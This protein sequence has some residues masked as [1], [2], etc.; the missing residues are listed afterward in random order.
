MTSPTR[1]SRRAFLASASALAAPAIISP[2][3]AQIAADTDVAIIGAGAAGIAAAR[4]VAAGGRSH[5]LLEAAPRAG[6]RART[7]EVFGMP[8]DLGANRFASTESLDAAISDTGVE[9]SDV[10]SARRLYIGDREAKES[11]YEAFAAAIGRTER[12]IAATADAGRDIAARAALPESG[13]W[14]GTV[15][16][17]LGPLGCG[18]DLGNVSTVDFARRDVP[19]DDLS[20]PIGVGSLL[21]RIA[22]LLNLRTKSKVARIDN[23]GRF[24]TITL[25]G[26]AVV[27][28]RSVVLAV[29]AAVLAAGTIR[30]NPPLPGRFTNALLAYPSGQMEHVGFLMPGN[31]LGLSADEL[32]HVR[33][34]LAPPAALYGRINGT[35]LHVALFGGAQAAEIA[36]RGEPAASALTRAFLRD[37]F[38]ATIGANVTKFAASR[39]STDPLIRGAVAVGT[40]GEGALRRQFADAVGRMIL[41]GEYVSP[42]KWGT[43]AGAWATGEAAAE[44]AI[45]M[46]GGP[47]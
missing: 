46:V 36:T 16:A 38:G 9:T 15:A 28:A 25:D 1:L 40:P 6:G 4:R 30:F 44:R 34:G 14:G 26:G 35:D 29:P 12:A 41:A 8:F 11:Q 27:R 5:V 31:P 39:W 18:R 3:F 17:V 20:A 10:P 7:D 33:A 23:A 21:E 2:A 22:S 37:A 47:V 32:V 19:P 43:L 13:E 42:D 24:S 45:T